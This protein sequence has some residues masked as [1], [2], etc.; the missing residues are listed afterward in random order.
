MT[1]I[2]AVIFEYYNCGEC[3]DVNA[4]G[5]RWKCSKKNK[6]IPDLWG[7]IPSWCPLE[8]KEKLGG[9]N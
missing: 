4:C 9:I 3:S 8:D 5:A 2:E 1:K 7:D 6:F